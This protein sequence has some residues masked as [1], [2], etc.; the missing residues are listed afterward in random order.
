MQ[1]IRVEPKKK[2]PQKHPAIGKKVKRR[3]KHNKDLID[4][5]KKCELSSGERKIA[6]I[7]GKNG[8]D[9][10]S[11]YYDPKLFNHK[12]NCL[13]FFD[14]YLPKYKMVIEFD[15]PHHFKPG[16]G[17][18]HLNKQI[19]KDCIKDKFCKNNGIKILRI[20]YWKKDIEA[21]ICSYFDKN[22]Q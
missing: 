12:T 20:P 10:I 14:F 18:N 19:A 8:I 11:E 16:K 6:E 7:L 9:F 13:L 2:I 22:F 15:G 21:E 4:S 3:M 5:R 17:E 1:R